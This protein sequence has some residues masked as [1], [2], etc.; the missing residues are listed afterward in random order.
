M[1]KLLIK[2]AT[3]QTKLTEANEKIAELTLRLRKAHKL[4]LD[5]GRNFAKLES[6]YVWR[7]AWD[8]VTIGILKQALYQSQHG[9]H[10]DRCWSTT[11]YGSK[12]PCICGLDVALA[13]R[14]EMMEDASI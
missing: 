9:G 1:D 12:K 4:C 14:E 2:I 13:V 3:L 11:S 7:V 10:S 6:W 8:G 5:A